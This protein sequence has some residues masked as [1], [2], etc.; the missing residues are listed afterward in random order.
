MFKHR[1]Y[2]LRDMGCPRTKKIAS[3]IVVFMH[4]VL[5]GTRE[6]MDNIAKAIAKVRENVGELKRQWKNVS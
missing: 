5:L 4:Q 2:A 6:D 3:K 1:K